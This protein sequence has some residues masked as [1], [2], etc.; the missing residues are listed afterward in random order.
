MTNKRFHVKK[1][2]HIMVTFLMEFQMLVQTVTTT[3]ITLLAHN[4]CFRGFLIIE[5][6]E[7]SGNYSSQCTQVIYQFN[8]IYLDTHLLS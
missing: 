7:K 5:K 1:M 6:S 3:S 2:P 4:Y 8:Y